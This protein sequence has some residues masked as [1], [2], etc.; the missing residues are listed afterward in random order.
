MW[1]PS[2]PVKDLN[3]ENLRNMKKRESKVTH[4][5]LICSLIL[6]KHHHNQLKDQSGDTL[7]CQIYRS[8]Y[9][10]CKSKGKII[11]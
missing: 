5:P 2:S 9:I 1:Q 8:A 11:I 3:A 6:T 7:E 4:L 10:L